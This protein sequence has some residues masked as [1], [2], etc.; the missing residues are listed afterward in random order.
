MLLT[1]STRGI[2][3]EL[4]EQ[5]AE[6]GASVVV[7]GKES[8]TVDDVAAS[9]RSRQ[10]KVLGVAAD[11]RDPEQ[12]QRLVQQTMDE[13]GQLDALFNVVG[14]SGARGGLLDTPTEDVQDLMER[15]VY[16]MLNTTREAMPHLEDRNG[17]VMNMGSVAS[18]IAAPNYGG[19]DIA[20]FGVR[21]ATDQLCMEHPDVSFTLA[22]PGPIQSGEKQRTPGGTTL[23]A[24][25]PEQLA[26]DIIRATGRR[27]R[28]IAR[29]RKMLALN[30]LMKLC[31]RVGE[32]IVSSFSS[33]PE[34]GRE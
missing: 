4:A 18:L 10:L 17:R 23:P 26:T 27:S 8:R 31:P 20:N 32:R 3:R 29:P 22:C 28:F 2:G 19:Y 1:G 11:V 7:N 25:D 33:L 24:L 9:M 16:T 13:Y 14:S 5:C 30:M 15:N 12:A 34:R 21:A 6:G